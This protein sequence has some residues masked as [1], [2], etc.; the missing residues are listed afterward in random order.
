MAAHE[1]TIYKAWTSKCPEDFALHRSR[2]PRD[3]PDHDSR[4]D[5]LA[6][7]CLKAT[8]LFLFTSTASSGSPGT[9][10]PPFQSLFRKST[11]YPSFRCPHARKNT[12][13]GILN[14]SDSLPQ[15]YTASPRCKTLM[16]E[17][18]RGSLLGRVFNEASLLAFGTNGIALYPNGD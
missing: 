16:Q 10:Q 3:V 1:C 11:Q 12:S 14:P 2:S 6:G 9:H 13:L 7:K 5:F 17:A 15:T 18:Q 8:A 4:A